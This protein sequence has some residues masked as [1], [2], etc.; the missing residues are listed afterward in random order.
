[1]TSEVYYRPSFGLYL[2]GFQHFRQCGLSRR[3]RFLLAS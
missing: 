3:R 1:M 2:Y